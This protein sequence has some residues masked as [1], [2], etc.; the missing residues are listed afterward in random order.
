L[1]GDL[2]TSVPCQYR[3]NWRTQSVISPLFGP[4]A[5]ASAS[6]LEKPTERY[7]IFARG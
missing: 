7:M 6:S 1:S 3:S 5:K 2:S 4:Q